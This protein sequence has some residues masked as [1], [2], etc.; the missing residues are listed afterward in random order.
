[1]LRINTGIKSSAFG[2]R[3]DEC[4]LACLI[5]MNPSEFILT[6]NPF[7]CKNKMQQNSV[8]CFALD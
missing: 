2:Y 6:T 5:H 8:K 4:I 7:G 3:E 1:M